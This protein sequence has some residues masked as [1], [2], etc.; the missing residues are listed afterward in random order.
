LETILTSPITPSIFGY[1]VD[2]DGENVLVS[3]YRRYSAYLFDS[4]TGDLLY[5]FNIPGVLGDYGSAVAIS[6]TNIIIGAHTDVSGSVAQAGS[7]YY[8]SEAVATTDHYLVYDVKETKHTDKFE[9]MTVELSDQ[10][11]TDAIYK[12]EKPHHLYNPVQKTHDGA[13]TE[14]SDEISHLL[15][16]KIKTPKDADK[17]EK[18]TNVLVQN[19]FGDI[20]VDVKKP[21]LLLVPS[22]KNHFT[23]PDE[24][25][26]ITINHFKCYDVKESKDTPKFVKRTVTIYDPNFELTQDFEVKK[27]KHLCTPVDKNGEGIVDAENHLMCYDLK[28]MKGEPKFEKRNVFTNNQFGSDD[29]EVKKQHQLCVPSIKTLL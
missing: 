26:P 21:K 22:A 14:I 11:E 7:A 9:K 20:I 10:F 24:L 25:N 28:K 8:Y 4:S 13:T 12:V 2:I 16:Y 19:Q 17:F 27:P 3:D 18:V 23:V 29:L 1:S 6:G 5:T 15:G